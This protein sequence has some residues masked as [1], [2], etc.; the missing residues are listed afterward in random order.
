[1][2]KSSETWGVPSILLK[3]KNREPPD[4]QNDLYPV[5]KRHSLSKH[6]SMFWI[7]SRVMLYSKTE[8]G[9]RYVFCVRE[10]MA[11]SQADE[12]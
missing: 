1:M 7:L 9:E 11:F 4:L 8:N 5:V 2:L 10:K 6:L 3:A 12:S